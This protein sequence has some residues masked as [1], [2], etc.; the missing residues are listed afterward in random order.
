MG[1][2]YDNFMS[3]RDSGMDIEESTTRS[4]KPLEPSRRADAGNDT[5]GDSSDDIKHNIRSLKRTLCDID[6]GGTEHP[7]TA[8]KKKKYNKETAAAGFVSFLREGP[9]G[10]KS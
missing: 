3:R 1:A 2:T 7:E 8:I 5:M 10:S 9:R 6:T 4:I